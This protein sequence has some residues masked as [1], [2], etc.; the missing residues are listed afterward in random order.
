MARSSGAATIAA[1]TSAVADQH[2]EDAGRCRLFVNFR[3]QRRGGGRQP[4][5]LKIT[6]LPATNA[7]A[8]FRAGWLKFR[9]DQT[10]HLTVG[11]RCR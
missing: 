2:I 1:P 5:G 3:Q 10:D 4:D 6:M 11:A 8:L 7:G 9:R